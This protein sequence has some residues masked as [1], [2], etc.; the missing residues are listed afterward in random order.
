MR[1][2]VSSVLTYE[3]STPCAF[4]FNIHVAKTAS[5]YI[6][7]E[8]VQTNPNLY[9]E[10][11][12]LDNSG[13]RFIRM[14]INEPMTFTLSYNAV[15]DVFLKIVDE[16]QLSKPMSVMQLDYSIIPFLFPSRHCQSDKMTKL[17]L[18]EFKNAGNTYAQVHAINEWIFQHIEYLG[19]S[20]NS[21]TSAYDTLTQREG[22]CKDFAH[23]G[24]ALCRAL[25]IP[26]RYF[27]GYAFDLNPP[28]FH[29][30]FEAYIGGEWIFFDPT[31]L[32]PVNGLVKIANGKDAAE[33]AVANY[34]GNAF[35]TYM[36]IQCFP[37]EPNFVPYSSP[38][39]VEGIS[40]T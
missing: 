13:T 15:V 27:T 10:V 9:F 16:R 22:V 4:I 6:V 33:V 29:A 8:F 12:T 30:C 3:V 23:L 38:G 17:A 34:F 36:N 19:G 21:G 35:C 25:D 40:Y 31:K 26:A 11:F 7:E 1:F 32:V 20:T 18:R 39:Y 24:I 2:N 37:S 28:D 14:A 5:Q